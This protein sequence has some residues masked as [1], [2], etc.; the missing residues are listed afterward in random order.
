[1]DFWY[2]IYPFN[3]RPI[4]SRA[5]K[6]AK[7]DE[8]QIEPLLVAA[9]I[10]MESLFE[11]SAISPVGA[12]GLMQLM[13]DTAAQIARERNLAPPTR[14]DLFRP[15]VNIRYGTYYLAARVKDFRGDWFPAICSYNAGVGPVRSWWNKK[16]PEQPID[17]F[18]EN[19][20]YIDTRLYIKQVLAD[21]RNYEWIYK[22]RR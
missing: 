10:R 12:I 1:L 3:Y 13:P 19:I 11:P 16:P 9:L 5:I 21:Y 6:E 17:E 2:V 4:V 15:D 18:I 22:Q 20:P 7:L 14:A 8:S